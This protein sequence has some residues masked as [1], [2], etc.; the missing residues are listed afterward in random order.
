MDSSGI[1]G[2]GP[3]WSTASQLANGKT[4]MAT[5]LSSGC[6][7]E[8]APETVQTRS[9]EINYYT[10]GDTIIVTPDDLNRF[11][12]QKERAIAVLQAAHKSN[13]FAKQFDL[14][15]DRLASWVNS[16]QTVIRDAVLTAQDGS[17]LFVTV[18]KQAEIDDTTQDDLSGLEF[19]IANDV[20]LDLIQMDTLALPPVSKHA[21]S[22]FLDRQFVMRYVHGKRVV[23]QFQKSAAGGQ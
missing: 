6:D 12:I 15:L 3:N 1:E 16:H 2:G 8:L 21:L 19:D 9:V 7:S 20:D 18:L 14:L 22:S 17:L 5:T 23:V 13:L 4:R 11:A 10:E